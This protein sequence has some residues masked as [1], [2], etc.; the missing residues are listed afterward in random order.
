[1]TLTV[2]W[3]VDAPPAR[4]LALEEA[5]PKHLPPAL[6]ARWRE[7]LD[8]WEAPPAV[9]RSLD[10][11]G[12][13]ETRIIVTGQQ[14]GALGGPLFGIYKAFTAARLARRLCAEGKPAIAV[15]WAQGDDTDWDEVAWAAVADHDLEVHRARW[16]SP[17]PAR[18]WIGSAV[19]PES[20]TLDALL[21]TPQRR[22]MIG[23]GE[24]AGDLGARYIRML[25]AW[26]GKDG[27]LPL[28]SRWAEL[29]SAGEA[30]WR[31]Y[32]EHHTELAEG[33]RGNGKRLRSGGAPA[34]LDDDTCDHGLFPLKG[35]RRGEIDPATWESTVDRL[36]DAGQPERLAPSV[37]LRALLQDHLFGTVTQ[38]VGATEAAYL[39]QLEPL[40]R[41]MGVRPPVR[42]SRLRATLVPRGLIPAERVSEVAHDPE[43]W[44]TEQAQAEIPAGARAALDHL[45]RD[46]AEGLD[47]LTAAGASLAK[48]LPQLAEAA[49]RKMDGQLGR[50]EETLDRRA[51][52]TL[53][54]AHPELKRL[55]E[56]LRP[57][58]GE[59]ERGLSVATLAVLLGTEAPG[60]VARL[61][62][63]H[64][65]RLAAGETHHFAL[66]IPHA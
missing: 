48:D 46:L 52:Q 47:T 43:G 35:E 39:L 40:Y 32:R 53:Y 51:R 15:F 28:D 14:T 8:R 61:A 18:H 11:L 6:I 16:E 3:P 58:R 34:P 38:V 41:F 44:I 17:L 33:V 2:S 27:L 29:R 20:D 60:A 22:A 30:V 55:P 36:L 65:D 31:N 62:D 42:L 13:P 50:L 21:E 49:R 9:R 23:S 4:S 57:R 56:F 12:N 26:C 25:L 37:L 19:L 59:Q 54:K 24:P 66:E 5:G 63:L 64:L 45:R 7:A 10:L 1:M